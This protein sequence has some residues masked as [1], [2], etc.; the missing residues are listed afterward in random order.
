MHTANLMWFVLHAHYCSLRQAEGMFGLQV[1]FGRGCVLLCFIH[2]CVV[3]VCV[4][5]LCVHITRDPGCKKKFL[6]TA[7]CCLYVVA[8]DCH[9]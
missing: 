2:V 6:F 8:H 3:W 7:Y 9:R 1:Y 5:L 4:R